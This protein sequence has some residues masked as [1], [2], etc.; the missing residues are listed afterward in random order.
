M[1]TKITFSFIVCFVLIFTTTNYAQL[2]K[3]LEQAY[4]KGQITVDEMMLNKIYRLFDPSKVNSTY[5]S[6]LTSAIKCGSNRN[7]QGLGRNQHIKPWRFNTI[8]LYK[9]PHLL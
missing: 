1:K 8:I 7:L 2:F 5:V 6:D 9:Q 3:Q 4:D